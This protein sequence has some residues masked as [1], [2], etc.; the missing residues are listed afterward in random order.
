MKTAKRLS[1]FLWVVFSVLL[2]IG[3]HT[4]L[5]AYVSEELKQRI[6][7]LEKQFESEEKEE[8]S[9][10]D[11]ISI[12]GVVAGTYQYQSVDNAP[13]Y[14]DTGRGAFIFQPEVGIALTD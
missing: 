14:D 12:G 4:A 13:G 9:I 1:V 3:P 11:K 5:S 2:L 8:K 6:E 10:L 7:R